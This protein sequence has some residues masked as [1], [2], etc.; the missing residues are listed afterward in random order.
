MY[1]GEK[2]HKGKIQVVMDSFLNEV[3]CKL[4]SDKPVLT[5]ISQLRV[6]QWTWQKALHPGQGEAYARNLQSQMENDTFEN[7]KESFTQD[8]EENLLWDQLQT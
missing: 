8:I 5:K 2:D 4:R 3:L 6:R 7:L 1:V